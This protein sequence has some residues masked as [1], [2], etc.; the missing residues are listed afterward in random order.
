V[1]RACLSGLLLIQCQFVCAGEADVLAANVNCNAES[2]C[3]FSVSV[4]H[5]DEGW[6][7][8]ANRW[9]ILDTSGNVL[10]VRELAHPHE[11]EQPFTRSLGNVKVP[12]DITEVVIRAHDSVHQYGGRELVVKLRE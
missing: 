7:H 11:N 9:E 8:Y 1:K 10:G 3:S 12:G 4:R 6:E 5:D 2:V